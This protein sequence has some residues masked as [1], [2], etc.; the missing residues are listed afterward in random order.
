M[1]YR[2]QLFDKAIFVINLNWLSRFWS[3]PK[4]KEGWVITNF[5]C[6]PL[7]GRWHYLIF[8]QTFNDANYIT[9]ANWEVIKITNHLFL[10]I[11]TNA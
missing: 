9:G 7:A 5:K 1:R 6:S 3:K 10:R 4:V 8:Y 11:Q 2:G